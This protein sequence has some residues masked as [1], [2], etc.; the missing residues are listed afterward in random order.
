ML[1]LLAYVLGGTMCLA[2]ASPT[3]ADI[4]HALNSPHR[5]VRSSDTRVMSA[6]AQGMR[7]S[8]T[9]ASLVLALNRSDV[10]VYIQPAERLR[11]TMLGRMMLLTKAQTKSRRYVRIQVLAQ[12]PMDELVSIIGHELQHAMEIADHPHVR[13]EATLASLYQRLGAGR[14]DALGFDTEA[15]Q[16][17]GTQIRKELRTASRVS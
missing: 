4:D 5:Q 7:R 16:Q 12:I 3:A 9:F 1:H 17:A 11:P 10:I 15:A 14:S 8:P 2:G 6:L 13:D